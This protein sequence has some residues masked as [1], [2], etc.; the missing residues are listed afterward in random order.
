M[1]TRRSFLA[2]VALSVST[3]KVRAQVTTYPSRPVRLVVP[4]PPGGFPD[5]V[6]R[7]LAERLVP[8]LG[9]PVIVE[10][11]PGAGGNVAAEFVARQPADGHILLM[12]DTAYVLNKSFFQ[13]LS[14]DLLKDFDPVTLVAVQPFVLAVNPRMPI[15]S[16]KDLIAMARGKPGV[17]TYG[18][19]GIGSPHH[20]ATERL[21]AMTGIDVVHVP[22]KGAQGIL[23]ALMSG[24]ISFTIGGMYSTL[25]QI[26]A[27]KL[28]AI[29]VTGRERTPVMPELPTFAEAGPLPGYELEAWEG[30]LAP[31]GTPPRI[32]ERLNAEI[33]RVVADPQFAKEKLYPLGLEPLGSTP[34]RFG[35]VMEAD[36]ESYARIAKAANM[37]PE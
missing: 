24:E 15:K 31:A 32:I 34:R 7:L 3:A 19:A 29:A 14:Y 35:E 21:K 16:L 23:P 26:R 20:F 2:L 18:T 27:G 10:N 33:N 8:V 25:N 30:V 9:Q 12:A 11:R 6:S 1:I 37:K 13:K 36:I 5:Y 4:L 22:Y 28:R 17:L